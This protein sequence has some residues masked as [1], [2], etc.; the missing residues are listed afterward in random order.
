[1]EVKSGKTGTLRSLLNPSSPN[2]FQR[3][4]FWLIF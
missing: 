4:H 2:L 1:V 3:R